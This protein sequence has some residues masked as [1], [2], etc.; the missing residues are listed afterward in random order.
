MVRGIDFYDYVRADLE[1]R[2]NVNWI[3]GNVDAVI[4]GD[5]SAVLQVDGEEYCGSWIFR[6]HF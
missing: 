4:D 3:Q 6:Q 5:E 2:P 1:T